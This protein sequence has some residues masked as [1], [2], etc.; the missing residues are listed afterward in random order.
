MRSARTRAMSS[1]S[2][3]I[4]RARA[5]PGGARLRGHLLRGRR[6]FRCSWSSSRRRGCHVVHH[7]GFT[8]VARDPRCRRRAC[9][10]R[11]CL[12]RRGPRHLLGRLR[13]GPDGG[14]RQGFRRRRLRRPQ[15]ASHPLDNPVWHSLTT[16]HAGL[17]L[18]ADGAARYPASIVPFAAVG[19]PSARAANQLTSLVDD[20]ESVFVVNVAPEAPPGWPRARRSRCSR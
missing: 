6:R 9:R 10:R 12:G 5:R 14:D 11:A 4:H 18:T 17:A 7:W 8:R 16:Q 15:L 3:P 1:A 2:S 13:H 20:A 19:E